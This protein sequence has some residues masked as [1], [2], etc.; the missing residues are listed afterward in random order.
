MTTRRFQSNTPW[1][2]RREF[3]SCNELSWIRRNFVCTDSCKCISYLLTRNRLRTTEYHAMTRI[4]QWIR[5]CVCCLWLL[6]NVHSLLFSIVLFTLHENLILFGCRHAKSARQDTPNGNTSIIRTQHIYIMRVASANKV[7]KKRREEERI[8]VKA[9]ACP[10]GTKDRK[11]KKWQQYFIVYA[12]T[13]HSFFMMHAKTLYAIKCPQIFCMHHKN[14][15][16][17]CNA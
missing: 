6:C 1:L 10:R 7:K 2:I 12:F 15:V 4:A 13:V 5:K 17:L 16:T 11:Q 9:K 14:C 3:G 8:K